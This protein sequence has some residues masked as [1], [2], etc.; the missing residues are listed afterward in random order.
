MP[1]AIGLARKAEQLEPTRA[2]YHVLSGKI[3]V[4]MGKPHEAADFAQFVA[5]RWPG[6]NHNEAVEL[7]NSIPQEQRPAGV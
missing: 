3:L 2:G 5:Q 1:N 7:W 6:P 4:R